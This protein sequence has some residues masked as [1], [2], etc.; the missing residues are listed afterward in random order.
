MYGKVVEYPDGTGIITVFKQNRTSWDVREKKDVEKDKKSLFFDDED[1]YIDNKER[2]NR[3]A[4]KR[5]RDYVKC[6]QFTHFVTLTFK[7]EFDT[8]KLRLNKLQN[9]LKYNRKKYGNFGY[10]LVPERHANG[11]IHFHG[12]ID[13]ECFN[14]L[15]A[16]NSKGAIEF[17][18]EPVYNISEWS[19]TGFSTATEIRNRNKVANYI[20]KYMSKDFDTTVGKHKKKYWCSKGLNKPVE[21][22][23]NF[24]LDPKLV[25]GPDFENEYVKIYN[26]DDVKII[27]E[28]EEYHKKTWA[29]SSLSVT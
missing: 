7:P 1:D 19:K 22:V 26:V 11:M 3:R 6:N 4:K 15:A 29:V 2:A 27:P 25:G 9:W 16:E 13:L 12:V 8:D 24:V 17:K 21:T 5:V 10:V 23:L 20:T 28:I 18:G 14:L